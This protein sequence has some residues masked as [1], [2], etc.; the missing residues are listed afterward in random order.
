[1]RFILAGA[2]ATI[3]LVSPALA[4]P[5]QHWSAVNRITLS[6]TGDL[7]LDGG[8]LIFGTDGSISVRLVKSHVRGQWSETNA[9]QLGDIYAVDPPAKPTSGRG[10]VLCDKPAT[11]IVLSHPVPSDLDMSVYTGP[12]PPKSD[13]SDEACASFSYAAD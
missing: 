10:D 2:L 11:Y 3:V 8:R 6:A 4:Q 7:T 1:M 9:A 12:N 5:R 13:G